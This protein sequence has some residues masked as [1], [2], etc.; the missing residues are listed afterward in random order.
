MMLDDADL[1]R[2]RYNYDP[3]TGEF[4]W[5]NPP[6]KASRAKAQ[7]GMSAGTLSNGMLMLRLGKSS[8]SSAR[9]VWLYVHGH[10][11]ERQVHYRDAGLP[12]PA[13]NR[14]DNIR[15]AGGDESELTA[16]A[17]R[18]V[19]GYNP[20]TGIFT[21]LVSRRGVQRGATA[22]GIKEGNEGR[23]HRY[24]RIDGIDYPAQR[25]AWLYAHGRLPAARI[26]F[27]NDDPLDCSLANLMEG[28]FEHGTRQVP[29]LT[30]EERRE[31]YLL[32]QRKGSL[33]KNFDLSLDEYT[34]LSA[35]Q[36]DCCAICGQPETETRHGKVK[37]LAVD[38][39]HAT[40]AV[41]GLLCK[42]CNTGIGLMLDD[43]TILRAAATYLEAH[44]EKARAA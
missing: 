31:R 43:P 10:W 8:H 15:L 14:I 13:R 28:E 32:A 4:R 11:P 19:V 22:G 1:V 41:R 36:G 25:L 20:T 44:A 26:V 7:P 9:I 30:Y 37:E 5:R 16:D 18:R 35:T 39:D 17:L 33:R 3:E 34:A 27:K 38:H 21:W 29:L 24:L 2:F 40:G 42:G 6:E 12:L 23:G